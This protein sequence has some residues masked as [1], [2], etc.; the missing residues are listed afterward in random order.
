M[1]DRLSKKLDHALKIGLLQ[2]KDHARAKFS[3]S[4]PESGFINPESV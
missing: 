2:T 4:R 3:Y 1:L